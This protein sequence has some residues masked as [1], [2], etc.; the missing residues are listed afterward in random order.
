MRFLN[1]KIIAI[2]ILLPAA[3]YNLSAFFLERYLES[4]YTRAITDRFIGDVE[5]LLEGRVRLKDAV[6]QNI[7]SYLRTRT[8]IALGAK[9][10]VT[11][12]SKSGTILYPDVFQNPG[13]ITADPTRPIAAPDPVQV[14]AEN[15]T[16]LDEGLLLDVETELEHGTLLPT[17]MLA[18]N[19]SLALLIVYGFYRSAARKAE[20]DDRE[21]RMEIDRMRALETEN[22]GR[23]EALAREREDLQ[24]EFEQLQEILHDE[25]KKAGRNEDEL[26]EEIEDLEARLNRNLAAQDSQQQEI[27]SL[28]EKI[29][30]YEKRRR[31]T[32]RQKAK[33]FDTIKKRFNTLYKNI[34]I[35]DRAVSGFVDLND[36]L[37]IKAEEIIHQLNADPGLVTI[38][39]KVFGGKGQKT[40]LEV[41]FAFKGRLYFRNTRD[42]RVEVLAIGTKNTQARE[43]EF[44]SRL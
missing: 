19:L 7:D 32:G 15:Y 23:L 35:H 42:K 38:K 10:K 6:K 1:F 9:V 18:F 2:A 24:A 39:R 36:D 16:L 3:M 37:K 25:Q 30:Q 14:A 4:R 26:I 22:T 41:V 8:L 17:L 33:A 5:P 40:V 28:E 21:L 13:S 31:K 29:N 43:L 34:D 27:L 11:V 44:L 12:T 20:L